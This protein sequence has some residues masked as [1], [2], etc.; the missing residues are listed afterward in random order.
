EP[1]LEPVG[2][3]DHVLHGRLLVESQPARPGLELGVGPGA[4]V[5]GQAHDVGVEGQRSF[6][7]VDHQD[8]VVEVQAVAT[9][10]GVRWGATDAPRRKCGAAPVTRTSTKVPGLGAGSA[11]KGTSV[12]C[13]VRPLV[14]P[15]SR[16]VGPSTSTRST[17]PTRAWWRASADRSTT[18][19]RRSKRSATTPG[20]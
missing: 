13:A 10:L 11:G 3:A 14:R 9:G 4:M 18:T 16:F 19:R 8:R 20:G 12:F 7:V 6:E 2:D 5:Q 17:R 15:A 1:D